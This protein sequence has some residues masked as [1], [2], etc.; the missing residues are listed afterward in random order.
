MNKKQIKILISATPFCENSLRPIKLLKKN[1][2]KFDIN[3]KKRRYTEKEIKNLIKSYDGLIADVE[4][5]TSKVLR[6]AKKLKVIS[7]VG[8]GLNNI[9]LSYAKKNKIN[10]FNTPDAPTSAVVEFNIGLIFMLIRKI[11]IL[12]MSIKKGKWLKLIGLRIPFIKIGI[13]GLGRVGFSLANA[14]IKLGA[15]QIY[16]NDLKKKNYQ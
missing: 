9:D 12:N 10:V 4:P 6:N 13:L 7:R 16:Y 8:I 1:N 11:T 2:I 14:L 5:L 3:L 15:K